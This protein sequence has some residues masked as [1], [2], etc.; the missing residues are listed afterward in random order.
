MRSAIILLLCIFFA[1]SSAIAQEDISGK[2]PKKKKV[3]TEKT[4]ESKPDKKSEKAEKPE[5]TPKVKDEP[6]R[7]PKIAPPGT[8]RLNDSVYIDV[9]PIK[10]I[11]YREFISF[12]NSSYSKTVRDSMDNIPLYGIDVEEFR[13]FMRLGGKDTELL[14]R[15]RIR[16][17]QILSWAMNLE[18]YLNNPKY[19]DYPV[20]FVSYNQ[21]NEYAM[22]RTRIVMFLWAVE[23]KNEK[24]REKYYTK[25]RYRLPTIEEWE[26]AMNKFGK[27]TITN[28]AVFPHTIACT[29][30]AVP[31]KRKLDFYYIPGN[32]AEMTSVENVA[33]GLSW[34]D[35]DDSGD[36]TKRID[37][38]GPRD[39]LGFRC[40]CEIVEY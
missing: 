31:Q 35:M 29:F 40:V 24:Q 22:W 16:L 12:L 4:Q 25:V 11:D 20:V 18:E 28:K 3:K 1:I 6:G 7:K 37:Y 33:V 26:E 10:N 5:K 19:N 30:P 15:M 17:D 36:Y 14:T 34:R 27:N 8:V 2:K 38:F 21:A 23:A 9:N 39:W 13:K 32:V